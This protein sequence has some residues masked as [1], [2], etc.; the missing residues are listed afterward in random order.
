VYPS[1]PTFSFYG[2]TYTSPY[3]DFTAVE[4]TTQDPNTPL[5]TPTAEQQQL[6][7]TY[8]APPYTSS[9]NAGSIPFVD[10]GGQY[11][12]SGSGFSPQLLQGL[13]RDQIA[14]KLS[15]AND[16][17]TK[18]I[19]GHANYLTAAICVATQNKPAQ[20]CSTSAIQAI[21]PKLPKGS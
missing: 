1:T 18:A 13:T 10:I 12:L 2:S 11:V 15:N 16:P 3:V 21:E 6:L 17:V 14:Q 7:T 20:V 9:Q 4:T 5:Q 8:D 19:V